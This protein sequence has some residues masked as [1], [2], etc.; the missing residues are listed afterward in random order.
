[1]D[2]A[3]VH[4]RQLGKVRQRAAIREIAQ[5]LDQLQTTEQ[6]LAAQ[7][8][9]FLVIFLVDS[10]QAHSAISPVS[11]RRPTPRRGKR[12]LCRECYPKAR[13]R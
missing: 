12:T 8:F 9:I 2:S 1:M 11:S 6:A 3:F 5:D 13:I 7:G 4:S 10:F